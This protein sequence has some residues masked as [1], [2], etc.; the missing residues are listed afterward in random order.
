M[1]G[2][3]ESNLEM[4]SKP[5]SKLLDLKNLRNYLMDSM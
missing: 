4:V 1:L 3:I 5:W 2:Y